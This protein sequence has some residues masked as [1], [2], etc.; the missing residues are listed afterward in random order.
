MLPGIW[1]IHHV[2]FCIV[3]NF[4]FSYTCALSVLARAEQLFPYIKKMFLSEDHE[5]FGMRYR[6]LQDIQIFC[7][8]VPEPIMR[9]REIAPFGVTW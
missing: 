4:Y 1:V 8:V 3:I 7:E 2:E 6:Q 5:I 9:G